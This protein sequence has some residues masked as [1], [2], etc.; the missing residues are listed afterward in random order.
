[1][2]KAWHYATTLSCHTLPRSTT[3]QAETSHT[4]ASCPA[5]GGAWPGGGRDL[6]SI[7]PSRD[8]ASR[9]PSL[10]APALTHTLSSELPL[11]LSPTHLFLFTFRL[12]LIPGDLPNI[13]GGPPGTGNGPL[14]FILASSS[15][16]C[17]GSQ[18]SHGRREVSS[19]PLGNSYQDLSRVWQE[20][21]AV[22]DGK[23]RFPRTKP[24]ARGNLLL[25]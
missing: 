2:S 12:Y 20:D 24:G 21:A 16:Q 10:T 18:A 9:K 4:L 6:G 15:P 22:D 5:H 3:P 13:S 11:N 23:S 7:Q 17:R 14:I 19:F 25:L 8:P 1:M